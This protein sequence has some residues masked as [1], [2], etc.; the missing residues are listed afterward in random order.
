MTQN[1]GLREETGQPFLPDILLSRQSQGGAWPSGTSAGRVHACPLVLAPASAGRTRTGAVSDVPSS[2]RRQ[3]GP[4]IVK[5]PARFPPLWLY[6]PAPFQWDLGRV[7][8][9]GVKGLQAEIFTS[10]AVRGPSAWPGAAGRQPL[11]GR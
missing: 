6:H 7:E 8:N 11:P 5:Q 10:E 2:P 3:V 4:S 9:T 1:S